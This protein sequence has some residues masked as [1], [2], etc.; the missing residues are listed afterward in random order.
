MTTVTVLVAV[1]A[2]VA[3]ASLLHALQAKIR[4]PLG[5]RPPHPDDARVP[6]GDARRGQP[7][8][9]PAP[10]PRK[11]GSRPLIA[12]CRSQLETGA[13]CCSGPIVRSNLASTPRWRVPGFRRAKRDG[14]VVSSLARAESKAGVR[15]GRWT[16]L[17][18]LKARVVTLTGC[19]SVD[20][21]AQLQP[22]AVF[23]AGWILVCARC[24]VLRRC[25]GRH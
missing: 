20:Q 14:T 5:R 11:A 7:A 22:R 16:R 4:Q 2:A 3:L 6:R 9:I 25:H 17:G 1:P 18:L 21:Y 23:A 8:G 15:P 19:G 10:A 24:R 12:R 13:Q